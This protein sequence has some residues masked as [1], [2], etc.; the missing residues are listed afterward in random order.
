MTA[1]I[2][3]LYF[4]EIGED[5]LCG[6]N[7][8]ESHS[9]RHIHKYAHDAP[10]SYVVQ[11]GQIRTGFHLCARIEYESGVGGRR[12]R[13]NRYVVPYFNSVF[14]GYGGYTVLIGRVVEGEVDEKC[15]RNKY[16]DENG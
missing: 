13:Q 14:C 1:D 4:G 12:G 8:E 11:N 15:R 2:P 16:N 10:V 7:I 9:E 5:V 6:V 3:V